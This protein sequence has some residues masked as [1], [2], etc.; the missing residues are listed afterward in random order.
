MD[1]S[2]LRNPWQRASR[3]ASQMRSTRR[4]TINHQ[5]AFITRKRPPSSKQRGNPDRRRMHTTFLTGQVVLAR[6]RSGHNRLNAH[7]HSKLKIVP[8]QRVPVVRRTRQ[9]SMFFRDVTDTNQSESYSGHQQL[10]FTRN[11]MGAWRT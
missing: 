4:A 5:P 2:T 11:Y 10:R 7:M 3:S 6:L 9:P 1:P 8:S